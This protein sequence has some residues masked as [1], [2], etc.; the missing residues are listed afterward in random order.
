MTTICPW[1]IST[2]MFGGMGK[3]V[4]PMMTSSHVADCVV[5]GVVRGGG[6]I[7]I[8]WFM[9]WVMGSI[10]DARS[11]FQ[12]QFVIET[13]RYASISHLLPEQMMDFIAYV[14]NAM[15]AGSTIV[16]RGNFSKISEFYLEISASI[17]F[18]KTRINNQIE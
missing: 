2:G 10:L 15:D 5:Q 1:A 12:L 17:N 4:M 16:G 7:C 14:T 13:K 8:P 3:V 18:R 6:V 9:R 11:F